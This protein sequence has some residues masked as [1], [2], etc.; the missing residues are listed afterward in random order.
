[1][2]IA[3]WSTGGEKVVHDEVGGFK[4]RCGFE[5]ARR[6][7]HKKVVVIFAADRNGFDTPRWTAQP[8]MGHLIRRVFR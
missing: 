1:M 5:I 3:P 2:S 6:V 4:E 8:K 7:V